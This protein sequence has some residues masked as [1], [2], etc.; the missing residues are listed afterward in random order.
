MTP[1]DAPVATD[2]VP[3][4]EQA[5][6]SPTTST[7]LERSRAAHF[8]FEIA[9]V[10]IS[11]AL[12]CL[13][14]KT[15]G[16]KMLVLNLFF[17]P[18]V[19][20]GFFLGRY[21]AGVLALFSVV[22]ASTVAMFDLGNFAAFTSP[23]AVTLALSIWGAVLGLTALLVGTLSDENRSRLVELH[24]AHVGVVEVLVRYLQ[25]SDPKLKA[26]SS[27]VAKLSQ[28]V[29]LEMK[30]SPR[31]I[32]D[33]RVAALLNDL[34]NVEVTTRVI[35]RAMGDLGFH[36]ESAEQHTF[37]GVDLVDS[38]GTV[39]TGALS[40]L[41]SQE[42]GAAASTDETQSKNDLT[43]FGATIIRVAREYD[44]LTTGD[45]TRPPMSPAE[46][47]AELRRN[48]SG[49]HGPT[50]IRALEGITSHCELIPQDDV[51]ELTKQNTVTA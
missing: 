49:G 6:P 39:M 38:L 2:H 12:T 22:S 5:D 47:L 34:G 35:R 27:R 4:S 26:H 42:D 46:A 30:L 28:Q 31:E 10:A 15:V 24:E 44:R 29:A 25:S 3:P 7:T 43:P 41:H 13:M 21:R 36:P 18:V 33:V 9:L 17:L 19:L 11:I 40:L 51:D 23:I 20:A 45:W 8:F 14:Y 16:F 32:D 1:T 50:I 48:E 37:Q